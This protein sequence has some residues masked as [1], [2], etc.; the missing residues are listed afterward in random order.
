MSGE[1]DILAYIL[2]GQLLA[3]GTIIVLFFV[4]RWIMLW[5][6]RINHL[7]DRLDAINKTLNQVA[8]LLDE[9][10]YNTAETAYYVAQSEANQHDA[11][12]E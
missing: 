4:T 12:A 8:G 3:F 7:V 9:V 5:Y 6:W 10:R 1:S 2:L 11:V